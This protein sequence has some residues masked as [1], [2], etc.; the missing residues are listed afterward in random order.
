MDAHTLHQG[1][2]NANE[3]LGVVPQN[4]ML[5]LQQQEP[6]DYQMHPPNMYHQRNPL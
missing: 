2:F 5:N 1:A 3:N 6:M 4:E